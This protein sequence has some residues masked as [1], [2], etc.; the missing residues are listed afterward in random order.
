MLKEKNTNLKELCEKACFKITQDD[1]II[2]SSLYEICVFC[3]KKTLVRKDSHIDNR[4]T[5]VDG[6]GQL[7]TICYSRIYK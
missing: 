1:K 2:S 4:T 5:Y 7:C 3:G 6:A